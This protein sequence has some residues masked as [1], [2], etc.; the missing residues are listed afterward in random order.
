VANGNGTAVADVSNV[1]VSCAEAQALV[2]TLAGSSVTGSADGTGSAAG[3]DSPQS[4]AMDGNG[5]I[6]VMDTD[7]FVVRK[8]TPTGEVTTLAGS[9]VPGYG[10]GVTVDAGGNVY[11]ADYDND[12]IRKITPNGDASILAG[13]TE[14]WADAT[15]ADAQFNGPSGLAVDSSGNVYVADYDNHMIRKITP[16]GTVTTVA[17]SGSRGDA[18]G[19]GAAA[20]FNR[21][22]AL[23]VDA[24]G[25]IYVADASNHRIRKITPDGVVTTLAGSTRGF[26]DGT[27]VAAQFD[28]PWGLAIDAS[29]NVYVADSG[30][31]KLRKIT[32]NG[33]VSTLAGSGTSG[34][35][36][37]LGATAQFDDPLDV[38]VDASGNVYVLDDY[39]VRKISPLR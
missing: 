23:K 17:G 5:N 29:G 21:P 33:V 24:M 39:S 36:N 27:G 28:Y 13:S 37:G 22:N 10:V 34:S 8:V 38:A 31:N 30:N 18:D 6:Y 9:T 35:E 25:N 4:M 26:A 11:V 15:G 3:F 7:N 1:S 2:S 16:N 19:Q 32:P 20:S 14:G 12:V